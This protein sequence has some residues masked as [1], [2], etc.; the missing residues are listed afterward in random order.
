MRFEF[1]LAKKFLA[2][3]RFGV[4]RLVTTTIAI[5]GTA[6]GVASLL[7]TL[8]VMD[9]FRTDIQ[10]KILGT[11]P[12]IVL[13]NPYGGNVPFDATLG[14]RLK[15]VKHVEAAAPFIS[16]QTLLQTKRK[17]TGIMVRGVVPEQEARV[18]PVNKALSQGDWRSLDPRGIVLGEEL[19]HAVGAEVGQEITLLAPQGTADFYSAVSATPR[20]RRYQVVGLFKS[21]MYEY[22]AN[23]AYLSLASAQDLLGVGATIHGW[24]IRLDSLESTAEVGRELN[25]AM[26]PDFWVRTWQ[27]LN[28]P[29]FSAMKLERTVMFII[30]FL[31]IL[32]SSFTIVSNLL[33][34]TIEKAREIGI[35][36]ALGASPRQIGR[37]FLLN[38]LM[39][40]GTGVGLGLFLGVGISA[41]LKRFPLIKLPADVYYVD[42][43]P[44][45][46]SP[47]MVQS[48]A[49]S[50]FVLV[51]LSI[52]YPA[53][54]A[55]KMDPV[56]TIRY[57]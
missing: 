52:L 37:I 38:G 28:R 17:V 40:G 42:R 49:I 18:T 3:Q 5:G 8:A 20:M 57:G 35:L 25:S 56:Q 48:V 14:E 4:F 36:Q 53:R 46:L 2:G 39:L 11:Q 31:I 29:L 16:A 22:D 32:V 34:L 27:D 50:A 9:G 13:S 55:Q 54:K 51:M 30:L 15:Q 47:D 23:M 41:F 45:R 26:G 21:G 43:L 6:I 7:V 12:H 24:G 33:L 44:I 1:F 10:E 19:A